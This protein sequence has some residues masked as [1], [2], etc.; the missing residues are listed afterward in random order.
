MR[1][2]GDPVGGRDEA[3]GRVLEEGSGEDRTVWAGR[4]TGPWR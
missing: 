4:S 3:L 2:E 1:P